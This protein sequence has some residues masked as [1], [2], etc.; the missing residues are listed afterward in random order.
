MAKTTEQVWIELANTW[1][2]YSLIEQERK[3][4]GLGYPTQKPYDELAFKRFL[5]FIRRVSPFKA[6]S[7]NFREI[8]QDWLED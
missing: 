5:L 7:I 2:L 4:L 6:R 1:E 8:A 3:R